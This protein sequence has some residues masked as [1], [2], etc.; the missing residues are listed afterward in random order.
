[1][2]NF[3]G[4]LYIIKLKEDVLQTASVEFTQ[5]MSNYSTTEAVPLNYDTVIVR[6][7]E[8]FTMTPTFQDI[9]K[10]GG[11]EVGSSLTDNAFETTEFL[12]RNIFK[13]MSLKMS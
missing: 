8:N 7:M 2:R 6:K 12:D 4:S 11:C 5:L 13:A 9:S 1:M 10:A 3:S